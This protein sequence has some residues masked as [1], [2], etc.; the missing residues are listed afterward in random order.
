MHLIVAV[1]H[2]HP[3]HTRCHIYLTTEHHHV[4]PD[5]TTITSSNPPHQPPLY[6]TLH[7][8]RH[9]IHPL[10][11]PTY[12]LLTI[13][14]APLPTPPA[15]AAVNSSRHH[16]AQSPKPRHITSLISSI[17]RPSCQQAPPMAQ[18][19]KPATYTLP[20]IRAQQ[21]CLDMRLSAKQGCLVQQLRAHK[22]AFG[23]AAPN[24]IMPPTMTT[25]SV[26]RPAAA[27][28]GGGTGVRAD[29]GGS[30]TRGCSAQV[31]D[32][33]RGQ[34]D[35]RNQNGNAVNENIQ[36]DVSRGCTYKEFLA[37]N[38]MSMMEDFKTLTREEFC[39]SNE[40]QKL[41]TELWNHAMVGVGHAAY[42]DRFHELARLVPYLVTPEAGTLTDEALRNGSVKK[43]PEKR[44]NIGEP[45]KDMN[46]REDNK[47][48]RTGNA[49]AMTTNPVRGGYMGTTPKCTACGYHHSPE[50]PCRSC[51]NCNRLGSETRGNQQNQVVAINGGQGRGNQSNQARGRA[52][53]LG[54]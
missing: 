22:G 8:G 54:A 7:R 38:P 12:H 1:S 26:G 48:N 34:R 39:P 41:E 29:S 23:T 21:G 53:M 52:F 15:A 14:T 49:F 20:Y 28:R 47:R 24:G 9:A 33:G 30:R 44:G 18:S 17:G 40:M 11:L 36:G 3:H 5:K 42:T 46:G 32:Q 10:Q 45:I 13:S 31:G 43:N 35:G 27:S 2:L 50:T 19:P 16:T 37:C 4:I 6:A 51:F 25:R